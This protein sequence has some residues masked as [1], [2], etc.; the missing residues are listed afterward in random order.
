M[1]S[2]WGKSFPAQ[3]DSAS[4][5]RVFMARMNYIAVASMLYHRGVFPLDIL[6]KRY[7]ED[8]MFRVFNKDTAWDKKLHDMLMGIREGI[9]EKYVKEVQVVFS[10]SRE[11]P[12]EV[13]EMFSSKFSYDYEQDALEITDAA[14][15]PVVK[16]TYRGMEFFK[17]QV[18]EP[19]LRIVAVAGA[20]EKLPEGV[21]PSMQVLF[22]SHAPPGY[23]CPNFRKCKEVYAFRDYVE[24]FY[25]GRLDTGYD[26]MFLGVQS[27]LLC[28]A[29]EL[30]QSVQTRMIE[31]RRKRKGEEEKAGSS[32]P[33][34]AA[35]AGK[36]ARK[37]AE[38]KVT[39]SAQDITAVDNTN[40]SATQPQSPPPTRRAR[41]SLFNESSAGRRQLYPTPENNRLYEG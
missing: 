16:L 14:G 19:L 40:T 39:A 30:E 7:I 27:K 3:T 5:S 6:K 26:S 1:A 35:R 38:S 29:V 15:R 9:N 23:V 20:L 18:L 21:V 12:D 41:P 37:P 24:P 8:V 36:G 34:R 22:Y 11:Q 33:K 10:K 4:S 2:S 13:L 32:A 28:N 17:K 25:I 31:M